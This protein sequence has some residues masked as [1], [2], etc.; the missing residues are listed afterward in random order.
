MAVRAWVRGL[1]CLPRALRIVRS[2]RV[3]PFLPAGK[4]SRCRLPSESISNCAIDPGL[5]RAPAL[6]SS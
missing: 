1:P 3:C 5:V 6:N 2:L 4:I